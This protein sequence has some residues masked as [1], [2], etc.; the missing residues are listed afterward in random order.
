MKYWIKKSVSWLLLQA[1]V[2]KM[3]FIKKPEKGQG[4]IGYWTAFAS[5]GHFHYTYSQGT[6]STT[7][8]LKKRFPWWIGIVMVV[9]F[10]MLSE[11]SKLPVAIRGAAS[12]GVFIALAA[13]IFDKNVCKACRHR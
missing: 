12:V 1:S 9:I 10:F 11:F 13:V 2:T 3:V 4:L 8:V 6:I 5:P 7:A